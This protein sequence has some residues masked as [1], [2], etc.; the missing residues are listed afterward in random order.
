VVA[1]AARSLSRAEGFVKTVLKGDGQAKAY[2]SY[3]ELI[4]DPVRL[5]PPRRNSL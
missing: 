2:G 5:I 3:A 1:V 4:A